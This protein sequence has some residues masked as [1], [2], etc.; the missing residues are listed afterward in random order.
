M[1]SCN[2]SNFNFLNLLTRPNDCSGRTAFVAFQ[3]PT[4]L[5]F[6]WFLSARMYKYNNLSDVLRSSSPRLIFP[7]SDWQAPTHEMVGLCDRL[8]K[9]RVTV[10]PSWSASSCEP[11]R[12]RVR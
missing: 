5:R 10:P 11:S 2:N 1:A 7:Q 9:Y 6:G 8:V 3:K 4:L 12:S